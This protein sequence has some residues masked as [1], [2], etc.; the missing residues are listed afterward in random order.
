METVLP[1]LIAVLL[2][3]IGS[4][5]Q[6]FAHVLALAGR[7]GP[8][9]RALLF[10]SLAGYGIA[11]AGGIVVSQMIAFE[12]RSLL[13]GVALLAAGLP[14]LFKLPKVPSLPDPPSFPRTV[15]GFARAQFGDSAQFLVFALAARGGNPALAALGGLCAVMVVTGAAVVLAGDWPKPAV[16]RG[17]RAGAGTLLSIAGF[18]IAINALGL[19]A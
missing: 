13:F 5:T 17:V 1:A 18:L 8:A 4:K 19:T 10:T 7:S 12:A 2:S 16:L 6:S 14:M 3:E 11:A 15:F 9:L